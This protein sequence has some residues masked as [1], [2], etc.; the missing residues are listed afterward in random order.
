MIRLELVKVLPLG[1]I[2]IKY[3]FS[4]NFDLSFSDLKQRLKY[5]K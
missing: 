2:H 5:C 4:E 1:F 3:K